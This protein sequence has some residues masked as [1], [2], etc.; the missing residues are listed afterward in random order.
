MILQS[1]GIIVT[2]VRNKGDIDHLYAC[3]YSCGNLTPIKQSCQDEL[4][5]KCPREYLQVHR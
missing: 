2:K 3:R 1:I 5:V 4:W